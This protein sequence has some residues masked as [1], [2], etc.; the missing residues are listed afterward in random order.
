MSVGVPRLPNVVNPETR[1]I[2][3]MKH[4]TPAPDRYNFPMD[5]PYFKRNVVSTI[6]KESKFFLPKNMPTIKAKV[7]HQYTSQ[8]GVSPLLD[9]A[10]S[11][12]N[13]GSQLSGYIGGS[14]TSRY[15]Q[16]DIG[17]GSRSD[18]TTANVAD[19][20]DFSHD[21]EKMGSL[22]LALEMYKSRGTKRGDT[23]GMPYSRYETSM[24]HGMKNHYL[25]KGNLNHN[26]L[27]PSEFEK[28]DV[29]VRN[30]S[31]RVA[32]QNTDRGLL[33]PSSR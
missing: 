1:N 22:K 27:G 19:K 2:I 13:R 28:A 31:S 7:P 30:S 18:F 21:Y 17:M 25:G 24:V 4:S 6:Q 15:R 23:F 11:G 26:G 14:A 32:V 29:H 9:T 12:A 3:S 16:V 5:N 20:A 8:D 10:I 33:S